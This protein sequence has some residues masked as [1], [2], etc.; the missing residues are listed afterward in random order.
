MDK[1]DNKEKNKD[2]W[3]D[4]MIKR[5]AL[6]KAS[7]EETI[8]DFCYKWKIGESTY[9]YQSS[10]TENWK[11]ILEISLMSAKKE[12]P[13]VLEVLG[14]KAKEGDMKAIDMYLNYIVQLAKNI[15]LK[16][17]SISPDNDKVRLARELINELLNGKE[18]NNSD[19]S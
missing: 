17:D 6:P 18:D 13:E 1:E 14:T 10:K 11:R 16:I 8:E 15:D 3:V 4:A 2:N 12:V 9:Y 7:R 19:N 5:E